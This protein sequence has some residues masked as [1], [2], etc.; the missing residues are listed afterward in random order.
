ME[1]VIQGIVL[2][3]TVGITMFLMT[4]VLGNDSLSDCTRVGGYNAAGHTDNNNAT[5]QFP[6]GT[7]AFECTEITTDVQDS[8]GLLGILPIVVI[9]VIILMVLRYIY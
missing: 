8:F 2:F 3:A 1:N 7:W 6:T 4:N 5:S 9:V